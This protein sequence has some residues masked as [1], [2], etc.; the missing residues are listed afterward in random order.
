VPDSAPTDIPPLL[1]DRYRIDGMLGEGTSGRVYKAYDTALQRT[2]AIKTLK[3]ALA[4]TQPNLFRAMEERFVREAE[5][6]SRVGDHPNLV[7]VYGLVDDAD[8]AL[9]LILEYVAAGTLA[10]RIAYGPLPLAD[11]LRLTADAAC[12]LQSAHAKG[13]VHCDIKPANIYLAADGR[14]QVGDFGSAHIEDGSGEARTPATRTGTPLYMSPEQGQGAEQPHP[15]SDQYSLGLV[16]YEMV[17]GQIYKGAGDGEAERLLAGQP[18][19]VVALFR[20]MTAQR[21]EDRF[22]SMAEVVQD[23]A[24][25]EARLAST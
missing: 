13:L 10:E 19:P 5:A 11:A 17:T 7:G 3:R 6:G 23:I 21:Q 8:D 9:N 1:L 24:A 12:G 25:I 20:R 16:L 15:A 2:V 4:A 14:A 18:G 22:D